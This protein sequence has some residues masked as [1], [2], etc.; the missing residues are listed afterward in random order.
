MKYIRKPGIK[1]R[2]NNLLDMASE[3]RIN[4]EL[5]K[6]SDLI[7]IHDSIKR[8]NLIF[9]KNINVSNT[10]KILVH[11]HNVLYQCVLDPR[12]VRAMRHW[13]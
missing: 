12:R 7:K 11:V 5:E 9:D 6:I 3:K 4:K 8:I 2:Q 10:N 1:K 13:D